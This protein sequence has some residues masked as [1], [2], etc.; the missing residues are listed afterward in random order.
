MFLT[1]EGIHYSTSKVIYNSAKIYQINKGENVN[2]RCLQA[3]N[4]APEM[5]RQLSA[6][7][8]SIAVATRQVGK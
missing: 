2:I 6:I 4:L 7:R 5:G 3:F 1:R 8:T